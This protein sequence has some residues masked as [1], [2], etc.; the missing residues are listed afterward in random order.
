MSFSICN[1][2]PFQPHVAQWKPRLSKTGVLHE[3]P[4]QR[5]TVTT[6]GMYRHLQ[7]MLAY[8]YSLH[9]SLTSHLRTEHIL[10]SRT[11]THT[12]ANTVSPCATKVTFHNRL[13][14][15]TQ[16]FDFE[17]ALTRGYSPSIFKALYREGST[18]YLPMLLSCMSLTFS[19]PQACIDSLFPIFPFTLLTLQLW[20]PLPLSLR[21][22][23][24]GPGSLGAEEG[25]QSCL[26]NVFVS[27]GSVFI[28]SVDNGGTLVES[29]LNYT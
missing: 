27:C 22:T 8:L 2:L 25:V 14:F 17:A 12:W 28:R 5:S 19:L 15:R 1:R 9:I 23:Y 7:N 24:W 29:L 13:H 4:C 20:P 11:Q 26:V 3:C 18:Q 6:S 21:N 10:H 16:C